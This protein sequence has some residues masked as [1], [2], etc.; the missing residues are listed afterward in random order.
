MDDKDAA[1]GARRDRSA[2]ADVQPHAP[3][4]PPVDGSG[5]KA[6]DPN[7][8]ERYDRRD[9][10]MSEIKELLIRLDERS[11]H[12]ATKADV[13]ELRAEIGAVKMD[14]STLKGDVETL[15]GDVETLKSDVETLKS[16]VNTLKAD[17]STLKTDVS[18]LKND[19]V[20]VQAD[21]K[22]ID[23]KVDRLPTYTAIFTIILPVLI[24]TLLAVISVGGYL[25]HTTANLRQSQPA[26]PPTVSAPALPNAAAAPPR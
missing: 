22:R 4:D 24:S 2:L 10:E 23:E 18:T 7:M 17:V 21:I 25:Y 14:V 8:E 6:H 16:D 11:A 1:A 26:S 19:M 20:I 13:S 5:N 9:A 15:K 12:F 3:D